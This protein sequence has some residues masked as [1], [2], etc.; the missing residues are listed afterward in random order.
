ME[1][2]M[3]GILI[4]FPGL[5]KATLEFAAIFPTNKKNISGNKSFSLNIL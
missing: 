2:S 3:L 1:L 4:I 5:E